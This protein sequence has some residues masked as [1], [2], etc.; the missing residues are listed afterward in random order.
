MN[1]KSA[2]TANLAFVARKQVWFANPKYTTLSRAMPSRTRCIALI[3]FLLSA[4]IKAENPKLLESSWTDLT[5]EPSR[6]QLFESIASGPVEKAIPKSFFFPT[7]A[8]ID[9][10]SNRPRD[11][12]VFGI[13]LSHH[14]RDD[15]NLAKL[16]EQKVEFVYAKATQ[17]VKFKDGKFSH[18]WKEMA[19]LKPGQRPLRG[20]YHFLTAQDDGKEQA[21]RFVQYINLHGG[22][23]ADDMP[24]C[25]DLEWDF[26]PND[27]SRSDRWKRQ[28][29]DKILTSVIAWLQKTKQ[30]TGRTPLVYTARSWWLER[31]IPES[32]FAELKDY[33]IWIADYSKSHKG[34]EKPAIINGRTQ[35]LWQFADDARLV[36]GYGG[37]LD[38]SIFYGSP[39]DFNR[40]FG[41][42][43]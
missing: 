1:S 36:D 33:P 39:K 41:L 34:T 27:P 26:A 28:S 24:P 3:A 22:M 42:T 4:G 18:Y 31:G 30:L 35:S 19:N 23:R 40:E 16:W 37:G 43:R 11:N 9:T 8:R 25:L 10:Q 21:E 7:D 13:D 20:A 6:Q 32:K 38:A 12:V 29:P 5:V 17:G 2:V 15:L 14:D